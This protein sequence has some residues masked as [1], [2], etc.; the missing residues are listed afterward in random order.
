MGTSRV[1]FGNEH[2]RSAVGVDFTGPEINCA[3]EGADDIDVAGTIHR[4]PI[5]VIVAGV[6][7]GGGPLMGT[8]RVEFGNEHVP[9]VVVGTDIPGPEI[10]C[11]GEA[12]GDIDVAGTI[13][14]HP[15]AVIVAGAAE[16]DRPIIRVTTS[17]RIPRPSRRTPPHNHQHTKSSQ[18]QQGPEHSDKLE[19]K[20]RTTRHCQPQRGVSVPFRGL[21]HEAPILS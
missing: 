5:A 1:E 16:R 9:V 8:S 7:E 2:V 11:A 10:N 13:H 20:P 6:A 18:P 3:G 15:L 19:A 17:S 4:H 21:S 14:R 12:A